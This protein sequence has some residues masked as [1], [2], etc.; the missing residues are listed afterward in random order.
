MPRR[1]AWRRST[2]SSTESRDGHLRVHADV[3]RRVARA[4][5]TAEPRDRPARGEPQGPP[6]GR[7]DLPDRPLAQGHERDDGLQPRSPSSRTRWRTC[8]SCCASGPAA[9]Q[10]RRSTPCSPASTRCR[11]RS[12]RSRPTGRRRSIRRRWSRGCAR[13]CGH[14]RRSRRW[15]ASA[16]ADPHDHA[17]VMAAHEAGA[18]VLRVHVTLAEEVLMPAVRAHMVLAALTEHGEMLGSAPAPDGVE[19]FQGR[20]IDAWIASEHEDE[21]IADERRRGL[22]GRRRRRSVERSARPA[23]RRRPTE[24]RAERRRR[25]PRPPRAR[26]DRRRPAPRRASRRRP[27]ADRQAPR[28]VR[29]DAERLDALMHSMG[30]LVIHRTAVEALT[31]EPRGRGPPAGRPGA[32][33]QLAGAPGDGHAGPHDPRRRRLPALPAADPRPLD[34]ARQ[35]GR[36]SQL[37]GSET[38]L[39]RTVVDALGDPLV[40]LVRNA[41]RPRPRAARGAR[42]RRQAASGHDRDRRPPRR[43]QRRDRGPRRRQR[44][45]PAGGRPQGPVARA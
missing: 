12:R 33:P 38:E 23:T 28:T 42:R 2:R 10:S 35:G 25:R 7:G 15:L 8:S 29:V 6:D 37:V 34:Q 18:R 43:R 36:S 24:R 3:P 5:R 30:E 40:H 16:L 11:R 20:E 21:T 27:T 19:Q 26:D 9:C 44:D 32:D 39:D 31:A 4:P 17:A 13:S 45:R 14:G 1:S 22:R 41:A